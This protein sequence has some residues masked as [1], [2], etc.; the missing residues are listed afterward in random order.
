MPTTKLHPRLQILPKVHPS[1]S[2]YY[3]FNLTYFLQF[4]IFI[5][6]IATFY[7]EKCHFYI[8]DF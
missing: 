4:A 3:K 8:F 7:I 6:K 1:K 2:S 5:T